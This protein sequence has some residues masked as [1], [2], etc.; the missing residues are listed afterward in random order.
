MTKTHALIFRALCA[1][2]GLPAPVAEYRFHPVR[3]WRFDF[4]WPEHR[5]YLEVQGGTWRKGG[6]AHTGAGAI[7]DME[8]FSAATVLGWRP[9]FVQPH[10]L[11][12]AGTVQ[13][14]R[15]AIINAEKGAKQH[16]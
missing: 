3:K 15:E 11:C 8:K 5:L 13:M 2:H 4:A 6:G 10:Q 12:R 16:A 14:V 1:Q 7:R 9:L